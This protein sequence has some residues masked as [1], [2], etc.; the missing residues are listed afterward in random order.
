MAK[1]KPF[2]SI[3]I[4][5]LNEAKY[6]PHLLADLTNQTFRD[7]E[8]I[9]VD[10]HSEDKTVTKTEAFSS[11]LPKL[12]ILNSPRRHVCTQRNL[13]A[14]HAK[15]DIF[16]FMDAD[17]RLPPYFLQG[18]K[19]RWESSKCNILS[20]YLE[21]DI[22]N[23]SNRSIATAINLYF[24]FQSKTKPLALLESLIIIS[25]SDFKKIGGFSENI[26][27]AESKPF[28]QSAA[29][30]H[31]SLKIVKDPTYQYSF[32]RLRKYGLI[33]FATRSAKLGLIA[34]FDNKKLNKFAEELYPMIGGSYF[35]P[36]SK[37]KSLF[38]Q[39]IS[40]IL[41]EIGFN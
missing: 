10:G 12:T 35:R 21:P 3:I 13:G 37:Q 19:Y 5:A 17:N 22:N 8:V 40:L 14:S 16:I 38:K 29:N 9:V 18:I 6:L 24:E 33:N 32:R 27:F 28:L 30:H 15:A 36:T 31:L 1:I 4:P 11:Q 39:K 2:F 41:K 7:F 34:L 26:N 20:C 23:S 25:Q